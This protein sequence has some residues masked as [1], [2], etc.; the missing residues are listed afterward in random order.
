MDICGQKYY[1]EFT[2]SFMTLACLLPCGMLPTIGEYWA[3]CPISVQ[4]YW[5]Q[6]KYFI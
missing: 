2:S 4:W 5:S 6:K 1:V 3:I